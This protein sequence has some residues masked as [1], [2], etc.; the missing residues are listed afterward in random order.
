MKSIYLTFVLPFVDKV[1]VRVLRGLLAA[2]KRG[3][4]LGGAPK[5]E[6][7]YR[8]GG[9]LLTYFHLAGHP[10]HWSLHLR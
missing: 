10:A 9:L 3:S 6:V 4:T 7:V 8:S 2:E 5:R 1:E